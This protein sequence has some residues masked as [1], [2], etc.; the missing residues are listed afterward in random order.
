MTVAQFQ[1]AGI[2]HKR[3]NF[4]IMSKY[5]EMLLFFLVTVLEHNDIQSA[6]MWINHIGPTS[7]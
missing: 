4:R 3:F 6:C 7:K 2:I 1:I 5:A